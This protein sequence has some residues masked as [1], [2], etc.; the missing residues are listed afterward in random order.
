MRREKT[1]QCRRVEEGFFERRETACGREVTG[2]Q[3]ERESTVRIPASL[4]KKLTRAMTLKNRDEH[5][6]RGDR[7]SGIGP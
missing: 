5:A 7:I 4:D 1:R 3:E 6:E 2:F